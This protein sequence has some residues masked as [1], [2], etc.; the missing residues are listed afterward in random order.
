M[1]ESGSTVLRLERVIDATIEQVFDAWATPEELM[2][3]FGPD[4]CVVTGV[5]TELVVG[6]RYSI[7]MTVPGGGE[8]YHFG[9]YLE[10]EPPSR[11]VFTWVLSDQPCEGA[12]GQRA[13][14]QVSIILTAVGS[15]TGLTLLHERLPDSGSVAGHRKGWSGSLERLSRHLL[16]R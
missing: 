1:I 2:G 15:K 4:G 12:A 7:S 6:G 9:E 11:L 10:I 14:T 13:A 5:E 8:V 16:V 3:W